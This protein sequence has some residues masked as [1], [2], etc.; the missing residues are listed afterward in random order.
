[1][2]IDTKEAIIDWLKQQGVSTVLLC[3]ILAF[4]GYAVVFL[5]PVHIAMIKDGYKEVAERNSQT[6]EKI[7]ESHEKDRHM[8][9]DLLNGRQLMKQP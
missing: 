6:I 3:A 9:V 1:V 5:V 2:T 7:V 4:I 8:F